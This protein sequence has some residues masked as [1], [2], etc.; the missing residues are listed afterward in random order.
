MDLDKLR[1]FIVNKWPSNLRIR[2]TF[3]GYDYR[4]RTAGTA[5]YR[6]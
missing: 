4:A 3:C 2:D 5:V 6:R 1:D